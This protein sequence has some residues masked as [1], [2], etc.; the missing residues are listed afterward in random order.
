VDA[1]R[2]LR[3]DVCVYISVFINKNNPVI[4]KCDIKSDAFV[5]C[6]AGRE[7]ELVTGKPQYYQMTHFSSTQI[8]HIGTI[9]TTVSDKIIKSI[10]TEVLM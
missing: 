4:I 6:D 8:F 7:N 5:F 1:G 3:A 2:R 10:H 9:R